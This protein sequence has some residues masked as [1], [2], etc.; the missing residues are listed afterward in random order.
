MKVWNANKESGIKLSREL[1]NTHTHDEVCTKIVERWVAPELKVGDRCLEP[2]VGGGGFYF[3]MIEAYLKLGVSIQDVVEQYVWGCD[4][5]ERAIQWVQ[6][7][8]KRKYGY[9]G[10]AR[11]YHQ[12][13]LRWKSPVKFDW[14]VTNPPYIS[15][16]NFKPTTMSKEQY[17]E[18]LKKAGIACDAKTDVYVYFFLKSMGEMNLHGTQV[19]LCSDSWLDCEYGK[20]LKQEWKTPQWHLKHILSSPWH[21]WFRD[22]TSAIVT[23]LQ[24][25]REGEATK[26]QTL[27]LERLVKPWIEMTS[28]ERGELKV[29]TKQ[30]VQEVWRQVQMG[31]INVRNPWVI[32]GRWYD[33]AKR[34]LQRIQSKMIRLEDQWIFTSTGVSQAQLE[35]EGLL[36]KKKS[37][38]LENPNSGDSMQE[39]ETRIDR[40]PVF[41]QIQAR[42]NRP[43]KYQWRLSESD[44]VW[45]M[46]EDEEIVKKNRRETSWYLSGIIDRFPLVLGLDGPSIHV[47]K[48]FHAQPK[49]R[50]DLIEGG[51]EWTLEDWGWWMTCV[52]TGISME[53]ELKEGTRKTLR[54]GEMGLTKEIKKEELK[55]CLGIDVAQ[56][57]VQARE[58]IRKHAKSL[59]GVVLYSLEEATKNKDWIAIQM[60]L[61]RVLGVSKEEVEQAIKMWYRLY[62]LRMRNHEKWKQLQKPS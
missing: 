53:L 50:Q 57:D 12:D 32:Q 25:K 55:R 16:K 4:V 39:K 5:D 14:V 9:E 7:E 37:S 46:K 13:Y 29:L 51:W 15:S 41:W 56:L 52:W 19:F 18:D 6:E 60:E 11:L 40:L 23:V 3:A 1:G 43:P 48:Y 47:S 27:T 24:K 49:D 54:K 33:E 62:V 38:D 22:D 58:T 36:I 28:T 21:P 17:W 35:K 20:F 34:H 44:M 2:A 26:D 31:A 42:V 45:E 59:S 61:G 30:E 10:V 8:L